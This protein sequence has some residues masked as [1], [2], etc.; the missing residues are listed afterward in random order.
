MQRRDR[1][2]CKNAAALAAH[3]LDGKCFGRGIS[4]R[5]GYH[6]GISETLEYLAD[7]RRAKLCETVRKNIFHLFFLFSVCHA[8]S[9][10]GAKSMTKNGVT[11]LILRYYITCRIIFQE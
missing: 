7:R 9:R 10:I 4:R 1:L 2:L 6:L 8:D 3:K 11:D 5:K